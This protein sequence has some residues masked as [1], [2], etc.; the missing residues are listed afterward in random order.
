M[1][2]RMIKIIVVSTILGAIFLALV[3]I[4][5]ISYIIFYKVMRRPKK[6]L[7]FSSSEKPKGI[8]AIVLKKLMGE[9]LMEFLKSVEE[10][11]P[12]FN[13]LKKENVEIL[14][15]DGL[16]LRGVFIPAPTESKKTILCL[17]GYQSSQYADF[18][19]QLKFFRENNFNLLIPY[20]RAHGDSDGKYI[21]FSVLDYVD[22]FKWFE[23]INTFVEDGEIVVYG[24][25]MG[26]ATTLLI[27]SLE[28]PE[29]VKCVVADCPFT[30]AWDIIAYH[31][32]TFFK[33]SPYPLLPAM[34]QWNKRIAKY[35]YR[36][37]SSIKAMEIAKV[38]VMIIHGD[39][40][41]IV[42]V[43]M[44]EE[45]YEACSNKKD[46][47]IIPGAHHAQAYIKDTKLYEERFLGFVNKY[48]SE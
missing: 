13:S 15:D 16:T 47:L 33:I 44:G 35:D 14:T 38:P 6:P 8:E 7:T 37:I 48:V 25:S 36:S 1:D 5:L 4:Y 40:D 11:I 3:A 18:M 43:F 32:R 21:G 27:T 31:M 39:V 24:V 10:N 26:G 45:L 30:S 41:K 9:E 46:L 2:A 42:P 22:S 12:Y 19:A 28:I 17:H 23:V 34:E 20:H 29:N